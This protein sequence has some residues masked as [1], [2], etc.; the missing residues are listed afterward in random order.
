MAP[1]DVDHA[2]VETLIGLAWLPRN[3]SEDRAEI[4]RAIGRMLAEMAG[5]VAR[6]KA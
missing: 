1:V 5:A 2:I 6:K 3:R 4:G